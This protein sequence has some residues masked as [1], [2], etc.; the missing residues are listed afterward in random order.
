MSFSPG[1]EDSCPHE[2]AVGSEFVPDART[3]LAISLG[4]S[5]ASDRD[6]A[7]PLPRFSISQAR[8]GHWHPSYSRTEQEIRAAGE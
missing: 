6:L 8:G 4:V 3:R 2:I 5:V 7:H 1:G